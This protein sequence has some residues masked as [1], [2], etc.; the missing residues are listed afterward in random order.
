MYGLIHYIYLYIVGL[1]EDMGRV[2]D[3]EDLKDFIPKN[4]TDREAKDIIEDINTFV[5]GIDEEFRETYL[6]NMITYS[7]V[8]ANGKRYNLKGYMNAIKFVSLRTG[9]VTIVDSYKKTFPE[10]VESAL[11]RGKDMDYVKNA[12]YMYSRGKMINDLMKQSL[13]PIYLMFQDVAQ[14]AVMTLARTMRETNNPYAKI[15]AADS[16]L[17][18]LKVPEALDVKMTIDTEDTTLVDILKASENYAK[19]QHQAIIDGK[20][21]VLDIAKEK[22]LGG[23]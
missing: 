3:R 17:T 2:Y 14:E 10:R 18:H 23:D 9:G 5:E 4:L 20:A 13:M 19:T 7:H 6:D 8:L 21:R 11:A 12:A 1:G 22:T 16:L 15:K